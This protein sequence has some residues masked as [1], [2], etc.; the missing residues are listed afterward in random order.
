MASQFYPFL[1]DAFKPSWSKA[2]KNIIAK[3]DG[4]WHLG[5]LARKYGIDI[6]NSTFE[7]KLTN[8]FVKLD[9]RMN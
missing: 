3:P 5:L 4:P 8:N 6:Y 7:N 2:H 1:T 9:H